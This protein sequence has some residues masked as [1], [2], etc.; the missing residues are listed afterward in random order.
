MSN[1]IEL[2]PT[3]DG[4]TALEVR[5]DSD[6]VWLTR[7]QLSHLFGRDVKTIG[8]HINNALRE[9]LDGEPTVAKFATV[10]KEGART[11]TRMVEHYSLDMVLSVG[12]RVKSSEGVRFRRW[13]NDVLHRYA[14]EGAAVNQRRLSE[15]GKIVSVLTKSQDEFVAGVADVLS[16][17][18]PSLTMLRDYDEGY[19]SSKSSSVPGWELTLEEARRIIGGRSLAFPDDE[20]LGR[21][22][23]DALGAVIGAIYQ[24]FGDHEPYPTAEEK[25]TPSPTATSAAP[26]RCSSPSL[27][28]TAR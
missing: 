3:A 25:T 9:E 15:L 10:Q 2:Y 22:R 24:G 18:L 1:S 6:T 13:A 8:K 7:H 17:Y 27:T 20:L 4:D 14:I 16:T 11:V 19:L 26:R 28:A 23:G 5:T 12:F 21:E